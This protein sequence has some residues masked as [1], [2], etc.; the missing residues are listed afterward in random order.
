MEFYPRALMGLNS[1]AVARFDPH[2][3]TDLSGRGLSPFTAFTV[4]F[5]DLMDASTAFAN[6]NSVMVVME[7]EVRQAATDVSAAP[8]RN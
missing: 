1:Q 2:T 4:D 7:L 3:S 6:I 8:C 5:G